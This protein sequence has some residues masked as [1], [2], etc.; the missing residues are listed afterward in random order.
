MYPQ[1]VVINLVWPMEVLLAGVRSLDQTL[2][3]SQYMAAAYSRLVQAG[4]R[5]THLLQLSGEMLSSWNW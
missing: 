4:V 2:A 3:Y 1:A 5:N